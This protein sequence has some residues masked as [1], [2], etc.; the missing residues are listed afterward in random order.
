MV[1]WATVTQPMPRWHRR[2][3]RKRRRARVVLWGHRGYD[4]SPERGHDWRGVRAYLDAMERDVFG[5]DPLPPVVITVSCDTRPA[6][7]DV[8]RQLEALDR[9]AR[10][11]VLPPAPPW[12]WTT[13]S[14][15]A[16]LDADVRRQLGE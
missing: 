16:A 9:H 13:A 15:S 5:L 14:L 3:L 12:P 8:K 6:S 10:P 2:E 11:V 7:E 4:R 1:S